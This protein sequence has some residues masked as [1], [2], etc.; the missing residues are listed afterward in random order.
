MVQVYWQCAYELID[1]PLVNPSERAEFVV[2][3]F[4]IFQ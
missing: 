3:N 4:K 2:T 1:L